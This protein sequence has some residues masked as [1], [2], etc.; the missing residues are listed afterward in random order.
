[1]PGDRGEE[2]EHGKYGERHE[3]SVQQP[4][5]LLQ[6]LLVKPRAEAHEDQEQEHGAP[7]EWPQRDGIPVSGCA[8]MVKAIHEAVA[9]PPPSGRE[10]GNTGGLHRLAGEVMA[11][12]AL[13]GAIGCIADRSAPG[14][15]GAGRWRVV[16]EG[17]AVRL[18]RGFGARGDGWR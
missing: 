10:D 15:E 16:G 17:G 7:Q 6:S 3:C 5:N 9:R 14:G 12:E 2:G 1:M 13:V 11:H 18:G 8:L 4:L